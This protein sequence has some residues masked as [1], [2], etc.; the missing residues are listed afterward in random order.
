MAEP[1]LSRLQR[2]ILAWLGTEGH[3][4]VAARTASCE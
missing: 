3:N 4:R 2:R 1:R